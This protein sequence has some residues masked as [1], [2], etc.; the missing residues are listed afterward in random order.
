[1]ADVYKIDWTGR[2]SKSS[3][4]V[5]LSPLQ[6]NSI[7]K[8]HSFNETLLGRK[9]FGYDEVKK[10]ETQKRIWVEMGKRAVGY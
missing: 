7:L 3:W 2:K 4:L 1:M 8:K 9:R 5:K 6:T 10:S